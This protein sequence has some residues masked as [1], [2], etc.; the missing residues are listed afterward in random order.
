MRP[1]QARRLPIA[2]ANNEERMMKALPVSMLLLPLALA[3]GLSACD[4]RD[5]PVESPSTSTTPPN[6]ASPTAANPARPPNDVSDPSKGPG[7]EVT[8]E[9]GTETGMVGGESGTVASGGKPGSGT[10]AGGGTGPA[11]SSSEKTEKKE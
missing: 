2:D 4:R 7:V 1:R 8:E 3:I 5:A 9:K 6:T 10:A 11:V